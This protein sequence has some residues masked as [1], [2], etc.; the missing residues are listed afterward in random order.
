MNNKGFT[1]IE[2][3]MVVAI[4]A[5]LLVLF[6]PNVL[7][8]VRKSDLDVYNSTIDSV[9]HATENYISDNR[10]NNTIIR[11]NCHGGLDE[12]T[13]NV[14]INDLVNAGYLSKIPKNICDK[15][16][17][18]KFKGEDIVKVDFDCNTK[19]FNYTFRNKLSNVADCKK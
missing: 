17:G 19:K 6:T 14:T 10:Y 2:V 9:V 18:L 3:I 16:E 15:T 12:R 4:M 8:M 7:T 5:M 11:V 1:L 13:F